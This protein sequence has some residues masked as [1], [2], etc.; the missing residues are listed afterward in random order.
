M[1][2]QQGKE[3]LAGSGAGGAGV[4]PYYDDDQPIKA[5]PVSRIKGLKPRHQAA[6]R[7]PRGHQRASPEQG[8]APFGSAPSPMEAGAHTPMTPGRLYIKFTSPAEGGCEKCNLWSGGVEK[9]ILIAP[10]MLCREKRPRMTG[11]CSCFQIWAR[12]CYAT[13]LFP[14][15]P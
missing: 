3:G 5:R 2:A 14:T 4:P 13:D 15:F 10:A 1:G 8:G 6:S 7:T 12:V 9:L 11:C